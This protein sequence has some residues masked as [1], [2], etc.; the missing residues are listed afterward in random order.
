MTALRGADH[1]RDRRRYPNCPTAGKGPTRREVATGLTPAD[2]G[3]R[4]MGTPTRH[5][6]PVRR[7]HVSCDG[8]RTSLHEAVRAATRR[9]RAWPIQ[10]KRGL[11]T[12][13]RGDFAPRRF[14]RSWN[15]ALLEPCG[16]PLFRVRPRELPDSRRPQRQSWFVVA[17]RARRPFPRPGLTRMRTH[18]PMPGTLM[19]GRA[20]LSNTAPAV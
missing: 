7:R 5:V 6:A 15:S 14:R 2:G 16:H 4:R 13:A 8:H 3:R 11:R 19:R 10:A 17:L 1:I 12:G 9:L 18:H 20:G